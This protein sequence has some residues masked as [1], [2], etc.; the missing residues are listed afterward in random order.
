MITVQQK[1]VIKVLKRMI[2]LSRLEENYAE[3]FS[4]KLEPVLETLHHDDVF[5]IEGQL[6]PRGDQRNGR[7]S[8]YRV[9][10]IRTV[11]KG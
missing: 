5:G 10:G 7:W 9:E 1:R 11:Q 4:E 6:D 2:E 8:M 3:I